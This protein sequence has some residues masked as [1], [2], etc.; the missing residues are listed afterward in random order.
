MYTAMHLNSWKEFE[1][2]PVKNSAK[3]ELN[4]F[5]MKCTKFRYW[6]D[7]SIPIGAKKTE[8]HMQFCFSV[9]FKRWIPGDV[10][11]C[12]LLFLEFYGA[13]SKWSCWFY[14]SSVQ[15]KQ[16]SSVDIIKSLLCKF[17][18]KVQIL[19]FKSAVSFCRK[20]IFCVCTRAQ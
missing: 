15:T 18:C 4:T 5:F 14:R 2:S 10:S 19:Q 7:F 1:N 20:C 8:K 12:S 17:I 3:A 13:A 9:A 11:L 6:I 16:R